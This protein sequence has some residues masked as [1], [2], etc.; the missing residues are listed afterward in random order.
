MPLAF[1]RPHGSGARL[2]RGRR[3]A[4]IAIVK[5]VVV[6]WCLAMSAAEAGTLTVTWD[7]NTDPDVV[8]YQVSIGTAAN[9]FTQTIDVGNQTWFQYVEPDT[10]QSYYFSVRAYNAAG[11]TG[12]YSA[13]AV[14]VPLSF[15]APL[16]TRSPCPLVSPRSP[17][18]TPTA[19]ASAPACA[20]RARTGAG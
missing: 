6:Y 19:A 20:P 15:P 18:R 10:S 7:A 9:Q 1:P 2:F 3:A 5:M 13:V 12:P 8:G 17:A 4:V 14:S 16:V 11:L